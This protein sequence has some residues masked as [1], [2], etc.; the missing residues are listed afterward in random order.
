[1]SARAGNDGN[2]G[3]GWRE[4]NGTGSSQSGLGFPVRSHTPDRTVRP[5]HARRPRRS[6]GRD[7][8][9]RVHR[10]LIRIWK[11]VQGP[12]CLRAG[13]GTGKGGY[14]WRH[15]S[16]RLRR[17]LLL[18]AAGATGARAVREGHRAIVQGD[19]DVGVNTRQ[20]SPNRSLEVG[21]LDRVPVCELRG[22]PTAPSSSPGPQEALRSPQDTRGV[23][24]RP[25]GPRG[26]SGRA[27]PWGCLCTDALAHP[28]PTP[29]PQSMGPRA[30]YTDSQAL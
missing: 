6:I 24:P 17:E 21:A 1:M 29:G 5:L 10:D 23:R 27:R 13:W 12:Q 7:L 26:A 18:V 16:Q 8:V 20:K 14:P 2:S 22:L 3:R 15:P 30:G 4:G 19:G 25:W 11:N 28:H 9:R